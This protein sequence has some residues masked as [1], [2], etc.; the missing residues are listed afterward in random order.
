MHAEH[1]LAVA[2]GTLDSTAVLGDDELSRKQLIRAG[3]AMVAQGLAIVLNRAGTKI[4]LCTLTAVERKRADQ[5]ARDAAVAAHDPIWDR[6]TH[7]CGLTHAITDLKTATRVLTRVSRR[8]R[9]NIG[10]EPRASRVCIVDLDTARQA[11]EFALRCGQDRPSLTVR[12]PGQRD[13]TGN[14][15]HKDGGHI[16]FDVPDEIEMPTTE[17]IYTDTAGWTAVWGEHQVL[18]PPSAREEGPYVLVGS[19]HPMPDWLR[20]V[21]KTETAAKQLR[22]EESVRRRALTGPSEIDDWSAATSWATILAPDG[23]IETGLVDTCGC[24]IYTAPGDHG[25]PKSA[26]AHEPGCSVYI[27]ERGHG[28]LHIWTDYPS[29][30]VAAAVAQYGSRTL[31]KIQILTFT[32][33]EGRMGRML[34]HLGVQMPGPTVIRGPFGTWVE[35]PDQPTSSDVEDEPDVDDDT[36]DDELEEDED[37]APSELPK[38]TPEMEFERRVRREVEH[39]LVRLTAQQRVAARDTAPLRVFGSGPLINAPRPEGMA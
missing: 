19:I 35:D 17:G 23:W 9:F 7:A 26:T 30:A 11:A 28:P 32:E 20:S 29:E 25:S 36:E 1:R 16:W 5:A 3:E 34:D 8:E 22:R 33:G 12:S 21:I 31:T 4:P 18:V 14:W 15:V 38:F 13:K 37:D 39:E 6:R 24:P 2:L 27:C 10:I